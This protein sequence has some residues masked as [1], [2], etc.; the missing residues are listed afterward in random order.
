MT[1]GRRRAGALV[2]RAVRDVAGI[3]RLDPLSRLLRA[4]AQIA[5]QMYNYSQLGGQVGLDHKTVARFPAIGSRRSFVGRSGAEPRC[6]DSMPGPSQIGQIS[7][8]L[9]RLIRGFPG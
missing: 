1:V 2:Q 5:G 3:D 4:L 8:E 6:M 9:L 7:G